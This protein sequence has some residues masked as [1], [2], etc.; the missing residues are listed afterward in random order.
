MADKKLV[1]QQL[2]N[3]LGALLERDTSVLTLDVLRADTTPL[4]SEIS[5]SFF[6][7][8]KRVI[9][10]STVEVHDTC[11]GEDASLAVDADPNHFAI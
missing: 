10:H 2:G 11:A 4:C 7:G 3:L 6:D 5:D 9:Q 8:H 1:F